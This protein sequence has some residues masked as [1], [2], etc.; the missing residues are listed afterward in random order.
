MKRKCRE[1]VVRAAGKMATH[2]LDPLA[3][4][5]LSRSG[6]NFNRLC[7]GAL[8]FSKDT[9]A[10]QPRTGQLLGGTRHRR[11]QFVKVGETLTS[12]IRMNIMH[13]HSNLRAPGHWSF[14][15]S[16][17]INSETTFSTVQKE[18]YLLGG[19]PW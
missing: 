16:L 15:V 18:V 1:S 11:W 8:K 4:T 3:Q 6:N 14:V 9:F 5:D 7:L 17:V 10:F 19:P 13:E 12:S 2:V